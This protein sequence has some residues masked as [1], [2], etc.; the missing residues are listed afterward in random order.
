MSYT[1]T[2]RPG[3]TRPR[4][5]LNP[6]RSSAQHP[7]PTDNEVLSGFPLAARGN[8]TSGSDALDC[9]GTDCL[10]PAHPSH[11]SVRIS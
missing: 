2:R 10:C 8:L 7:Y 4:R 6:D 1:L 9:V 11:Y 3:Q 5:F